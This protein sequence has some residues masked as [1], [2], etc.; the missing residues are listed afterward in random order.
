MSTVREL[1]RECR[2]YYKDCEYEEAIKVSDEILKSNPQNHH[3]LTY[4]ILSYYCLKDYEKALNAADN[5]LETYHDYSRFLNL[6]AHILYL[7]GDEKGAMECLNT[8]SLNIG[9]LNKK[10]CLLLSMDKLDESYGLYQ[11]L[12][13]EMLFDGF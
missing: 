3:A 10:L 4:R 6:K 12:S 9:I 8:T 13:D 1:E 2:D 7:M 5:T 11:S